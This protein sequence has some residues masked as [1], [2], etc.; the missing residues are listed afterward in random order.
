MKILRKSAFS[1]AE[2]GNCCRY[3]T[4]PS[5]TLSIPSTKEIEILTKKRF[6][7]ALIKASLSKRS[8]VANTFLKAEET[9]VV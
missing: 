5:T 4:S 1:S 8:L 2:L 6:S 7:D 9:S 3:S